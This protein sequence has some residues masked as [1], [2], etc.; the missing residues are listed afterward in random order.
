MNV[1]KS[2]CISKATAFI[3]LEFG[4]VTISKLISKIEEKKLTE[5]HCVIILVCDARTAAV[6]DE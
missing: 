3:E 4:S 5:T 6:N 1:T 2:I